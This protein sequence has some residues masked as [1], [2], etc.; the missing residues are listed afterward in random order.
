MTSAEPTPPL[1]C[2]TYTYARRYPLVIGKIGGATLWWPMS[3]L[4]MG[5]LVASVVLLFRTRAL[6]A[7]LGTLGNLAV[8]IG[9]PA[10]LAWTVRYMRI[11]GRPPLRS[12]IGALG[13]AFAPRHGLLRGHPAAAPKP[14]PLIGA[15][16]F[17]HA[18]P[19]IEEA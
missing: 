7:H 17:V 10:V 15:R 6:W 11:E 19:E 13:Y 3:V 1:Q 2:R 14:S 8:G 12:L 16:I 18:L 5:V 9:L 4:Q